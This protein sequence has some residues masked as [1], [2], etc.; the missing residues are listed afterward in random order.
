MIAALQHLDLDPDLLEVL[1]GLADEDVPTYLQAFVPD[2]A[3]AEEY[4]AK[5]EDYST[6]VSWLFII[7]MV[8]KQTGME[9]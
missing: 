7:E 8:M 1:L 9:Q 2:A 4:A 6:I 3:K 5:I